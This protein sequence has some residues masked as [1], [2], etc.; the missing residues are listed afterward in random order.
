MDYGLGSWDSQ[1]FVNTANTAD[2]EKSILTDGED[3]RFEGQ[4]R[5]KSNPKVLG[6]WGGSDRVVADRD[7]V[8][9]W[10]GTVSRVDKEEFS[11]TVIDFEAVQR[12][13][14]SNIGNACLQVGFGSEDVGRSGCGIT[15]Q[16][17]LGVISI[18]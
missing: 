5:V 18:Q 13:A 12:H 6:N 1:I 16:I 15:S 9:G 2:L 4:V 14:S 8:L 11:F 17:Q 3:M 10:I 7:R